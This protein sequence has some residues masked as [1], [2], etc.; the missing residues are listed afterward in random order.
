MGDSVTGG[1]H[2]QR[3]ELGLAG[4]LGQPQEE[5]QLDVELLAVADHGTAEQQPK[6]AIR[7]SGEPADEQ[8]LGSIARAQGRRHR[9][10][11]WLRRS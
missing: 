9:A 2:G 10:I 11:L 3:V 1:L 5:L 8:V 7:E 4:E 6:H